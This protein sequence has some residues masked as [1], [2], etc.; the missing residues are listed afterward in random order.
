MSSGDHDRWTRIQDL[1][2]EAL[3]LAPDARAAFLATACGTDA[4]LRQEVESLLSFEGQGDGLLEAPAA[5]RAASGVPSLVPEVALKPGAMVGHYRVVAHIGAGGM[6]E[7]YRAHDTKLRRDIV[8]K[9]LPRGLASDPDWMA[10]FRREARAL[11]SL[12]HPNVATVHGLEEL[13]DEHSVALVME[14]I[15]GQTIAQR[16]ATGGPIPWPEAAATAIQAAEGI[17]AAHRKGVVHRDLKPAN[18]MVTSAGLVKVLDFGIAKLDATPGA[19]ETQTFVDQT[20]QGSILGTPAYMAPEQA[21]GRHVDARSDIFSFGTVLQEMLT[22]QPAFGGASTAAVL[23]AVLRDDPAPLPGSVP[24]SLARVVARCLSKDPDRRYQSIT[25]VRFALEDLLEA[26]NQPPTTAPH[27]RRSLVPAVLALAVTVVVV[28]AGFAW[29]ASRNAGSAP[30][31]VIVSPLNPGNFPAVSPDG[32]MIAFV[33][34]GE[35][36]DNRDIYVRAGAGPP[37]QLTRDPALDL[38]PVWSPDGRQIAFSRLTDADFGSARTFIVPM[39]GGAERSLAPG[40]VQDWSPDGNTLLVVGASPGEPRSFRLVSAGDGASRRLTATPLSGRAGSARFSRDGKTV[41]F[42]QIDAPGLPR[43]FRVPTFGQATPEPVGIRG[44]RAILSFA[45]LPGGQ[46]FLLAAVPEESIIP[47]LWRVPVA[48]GNATR[49]PFGRNVT[50]VSVSVNSNVIAFALSSFTESIQRISAWPGPGSDRQPRTWAAGEHSSS[51]PA[52]AAGDQP[53]IAFASD[54]SGSWQIWAALADGIDP[55]P[56]TRFSPGAVGIVGSPAWSP[57]GT[58]IAFDART[59]NA[60]IWVVP[61]KGSGSGTEPRQITADP[62]EDMTPAWSPDGKWVYFASDRNGGRQFIWR[63]RSTIGSGPPEQVTTNGGYGPKFSPDGKYL[64]Y[65]KNRRE[66]EIWRMPVEGRQPAELVLKDFRG[67]DFEVLKEGIY[68]LD[69]GSDAD[70]FALRRARAKFYRFR[71]KQVED[72]KFET[73]GIA[74]PYGITLSPDEKWLY[75]AEHGRAN[76][77]VML[78]ENFR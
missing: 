17:E 77:D 62:A 2:H 18:L 6:G 57:D 34:A 51:S 55:L 19:A 71:T 16:L 48:G 58:E 61:A 8:L 73:A 45:V 76:I 30:A 5:A 72:L 75:Y 42:V 32:K 26:T 20:R 7:V 14:L 59:S 21:E 11:A 41:Y 60:D 28:G 54:R 50:S 35:A 22:G 74:S 56:L 13:P 36:G 27:K 39:L 66:G 64:Y 24:K 44:V 10:R 63:V 37:L 9:T 4:A 43:M 67:R 78:V 3:H 46:E 47:S 31:P 49:V 25:D 33:W 40:L 52:F 53:R 65:L 38:N 29:I 68:L 1:Y 23:S 12:N 70:E 15:H 69:R